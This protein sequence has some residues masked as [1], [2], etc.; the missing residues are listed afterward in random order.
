M[1]LRRSHDNESAKEYPKFV[2]FVPGE[3]FKVFQTVRN[4]SQPAAPQLIFLNVDSIDFR[5]I[6]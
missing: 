6:K 3:G 5:V 4:D 1:I 2:V